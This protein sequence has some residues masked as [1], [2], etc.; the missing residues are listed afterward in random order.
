MQLSQE[1][2]TSGTR[3]KCTPGFT[4]HGA[5][6]HHPPPPSVPQ[7]GNEW[8]CPRLSLK[9]TSRCPWNH[10]QNH[11]TVYNPP[12]IFRALG[13][14]TNPI[15]TY[16]LLPSPTPGL[17]AF[18]NWSVVPTTLVV[19][20]VGQLALTLPVTTF[21]NGP[22]S[23]H[24]AVAPG[25]PPAPHPP[26]HGLMVPCNDVLASYDCFPVTRSQPRTVAGTW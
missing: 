23:K 8:P 10:F 14:P 12:L 9:P 24:P 17:G 5:P 15:A 7:T 11:S 18:Q 20:S 4:P 21:P 3:A 25:A 1:P 26:Q 19:P 13:L 2:P 6:W 22:W 16:T